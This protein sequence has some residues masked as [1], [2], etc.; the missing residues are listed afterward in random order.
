[1]SAMTKSACGARS[2]RVATPDST[3]IATAPAA[4]AQSRSCRLSPTSAICSACADRLGE[5]QRPCPASA[6]RRGRNRNR[7]RNPSQP[8]APVAQDGGARWLRRRWWRAR[9]SA[10]IARSAAST[11]AGSPTGVNDEAQATA[12]SSSI[13]TRSAGKIVAPERRRPGHAVLRRRAADDRRSRA[14]TLRIDVKMQA[15]GLCADLVG[16]PS[17]SAWMTAWIAGP[18]VC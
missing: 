10:P 14:E 16:S 13:S 6:S 11:A 5:R 3:A 17:A 7:R 2:S 1:M 4:R 8:T 12:A 9:P 15:F 18:Q